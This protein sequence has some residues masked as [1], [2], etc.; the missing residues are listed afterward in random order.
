MNNILV[1]IKKF[2]ANKN[3]VTVIGIIII[4]GLLYWGYNSTIK[5]Q[6]QPI[7]VP[8]ATK[9][10]QPRTLITDDM[11]TYI[12]IPA[13]AI[14]KN[15]S[16]AASAV[17]GKYADV[18]TVIPAGSMFYTDVLV[19]KEELPDSAFTA[20]KDGERPYALSVT[21]DN[22]YGNSIFP[23]N[24]I[25]IYMKA[26]DENG[27]VMLGR[28]LG[29]IEVLAVKDSAGNNVFEDTSTTRTP[30]TI[31]YGVPEDVYILLKK[32][33]YLKSFGVELFPVPYGGTAKVEADLMVDRAELV[34]FIESNTVIFSDPTKPEIPTDPETPVIPKPETEA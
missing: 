20:V 28:L 33:E 34:S 21:T 8:V 13:A 3:T 17:V 26:T 7:R 19:K 25:D 32:A 23:G 2:F 11:I 29:K 22:T 31:L 12:N 10:I 30:A 5:K 9:T 16:R 6:T 14:S 24:V 27:Q 4:L 18:N 1:S 15:V